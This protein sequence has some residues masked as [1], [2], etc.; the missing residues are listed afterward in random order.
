MAHAARGG[1][2][3]QVSATQVSAG[4][5]H[6]LVLLADGTMRAFGFGTY[7]QLGY[8]ST[9]NVG[10]KESSLPSLQGP[11]PLGGNA[12]AVSAGDYHSL[13]LLEGGSVKAF[14]NGNNGRLGYG[15][16]EHVGDQAS[17]VPSMQG[18][19]SLGG[20]AADISAGGVHSLVLLV[21]RSVIAFGFG[22]F[23]QLG[24]GTTSDVGGAGTSLPSDAGPVPLG[25]NAMA[26]AAGGQHS[27]VLMS[28]GSVRT[29]GDGENGRLGYG[30]SGRVGGTDS[31]WASTMD[32][33]PLGGPAV[34]VAAGT[35]HTLALL[36]DGRVRAFGL[37]EYGK[38]G[39]GSTD[40]VGDTDPSWANSV[41]PVPLG[42][43]AT[44]VAAG[45]GH[46]LVLLD[47]GRVRA[48]GMGE[49]GALGY[50]SQDNVGSTDPNWAS[51]ADPVPL[52]GTAVAVSAGGAHSLVVLGD[53]TIRAFG[54]GYY[55]QLGYG[56][57]S[58]VGD[59]PATLPSNMSPFHAFTYGIAIG[60]SHFNS[61][62]FT[63]GLAI[64]HFVFHANA[65]LHGHGHNN[66]VPHA[67]AILHGH[68]HNNA[69]PHAKPVDIAHRNRLVHSV[70][71]RHSHPDSDAI[72][73]PHRQPL[74]VPE[75]RG[76]A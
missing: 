35:S 6:S 7:G 53:G 42:G 25:G 10:D 2:R 4:D 64:G 76:E 11:V 41:D 24:L 19:V 27:V 14:G 57:A 13:V 36:D 72:A 18:G 28:D 1:R 17:S 37:G 56:S 23:G 50:G 8:G 43:T 31:S 30:S 70:P 61:H 21:D 15:S 60:H 12:I 46:S 67:N 40:D 3:L 29:F 38:L 51:S 48:F 22:G 34:A 32:P 49:Y 71:H 66:A 44:A 73:L 74:R 75:P 47:D 65:I 63:Y 55:G 58:S 45:A 9:E 33:V 26:L 69:V 62:V 39:H 5:A 54:M 16:I 20:T 52:G 68:G 59:V